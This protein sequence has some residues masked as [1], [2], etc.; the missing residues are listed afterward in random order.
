MPTEILVE[1]PH[2][3]IHGWV[4]AD[5]K[6]QV[7]GFLEKLEEDSDADYDRLLYLINRTATNGVPTNIRQVR[8]LDDEIYEFKGNGT[9]RIFF[10]YDK[11]RLIICS[12][13]FAGK[14]GSEKKFIK[15]QKAKAVRVRKN[16]FAEKG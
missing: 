1:G 10:F 4:G 12:H 8:S 11:G 16:Y 9:A 6:C 5:G 15:E 7:L 13:G 14:K 2:F 3:T